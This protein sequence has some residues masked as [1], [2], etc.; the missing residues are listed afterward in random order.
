MR[1][2]IYLSCLVNRKFGLKGFRILSNFTKYQLKRKFFRNQ[3][4]IFL[5]YKKAITSISNRAGPQVIKC[6]S[7]GKWSAMPKCVEEL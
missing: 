7:D 2:Y 6:Q 4:F 5:F 3:R 1:N